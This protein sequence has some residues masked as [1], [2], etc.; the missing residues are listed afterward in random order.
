MSKF[1]TPPPHYLI[2]FNYFGQLCNAPEITLNKFGQLVIPPS[3][4]HFRK[5]NK[6]FW[7]VEYHSFSKTRRWLF[8]VCFSCFCRLN[9]ESL[10][11]KEKTTWGQ[12][13]AKSVLMTEYEYKY[14]SAPQKWPNTNT[15]MFAYIWLIVRCWGKSSLFC[16]QKSDAL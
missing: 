15:N 7:I 14:H 13:W 3:S 12:R 4:I 5:F 9:M 10:W 2:G 16:Q 6:K 11:G 1:P 8:H